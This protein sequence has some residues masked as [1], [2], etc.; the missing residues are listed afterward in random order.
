MPLSICVGTGGRSLPGSPLGATAGRIADRRTTEGEISRELRVQGSERD[1]SCWDDPMRKHPHWIYGLLLSG[2]AL[3]GCTTS[4]ADEAELQPSTTEESPSSAVVRVAGT[5]EVE[6][7]SENGE[8][9]SRSRS[10]AVVA[11]DG[12]AITDHQVAN[13][14]SSECANPTFFM[15]LFTADSGEPAAILEARIAGNATEELAAIQPVALSDSEGTTVE[16]L[17]FSIRE[18]PPVQGESLVASWASDEHRGLHEMSGWASWSAGRTPEELWF[19]ADEPVPSGAPLLDSDG[20]LAAI[21][22]DFDGDPDERL[23]GCG[24]PDDDFSEPDPTCP[25]GL[26]EGLLSFTVPGSRFAQKF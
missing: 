3:S 15:H 24:G 12:T 18:E 7:L 20:Q 23:F 9:C 8:A 13:F 17:P 10:G 21:V 25:E 5:I 6:A 22:F 16:F 1:V 2:L 14:Y 11:A 4:D 26:D 19:A